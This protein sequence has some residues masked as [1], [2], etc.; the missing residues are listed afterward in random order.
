MVCSQNK[1]KKENVLLP[2]AYHSDKNSSTL[3]PLCDLCS[4]HDEHLSIVAGLV[5]IHGDLSQEMTLS[6]E[7]RRPECDNVN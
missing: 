3:C 2:N 5:V 4:E 7:G 1:R 6:H